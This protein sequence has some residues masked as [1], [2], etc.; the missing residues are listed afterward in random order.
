MPGGEAVVVIAASLAAQASHRAEV[1]R[2]EGVIQAFDSTK[3]WTV[4]QAQDYAHCINTLYP[5][6]MSSDVTWMFKGVF[7][8][9]IIGLIAGI[10]WA[11]KENSG[12]EYYILL[13]LMAAMCVPIG[14]AFIVGVVVGVKWLFS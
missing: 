10:F 7:V 6:P 4:G 12:W 3:N 11:K 13:P 1:S 14:A 8:L 2:C 5:Q 9:A